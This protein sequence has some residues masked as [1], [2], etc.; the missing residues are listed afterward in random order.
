[1]EPPVKGRRGGAR[2]PRELTDAECREIAKRYVGGESIKRLMR[3][4]H[5][6]QVKI[7]KAIRNVGVAITETYGRKRDPTP[8]EIELA[9]ELIREQ[10]MKRLEASNPRP[11]NDMGD[12]PRFSLEPPDPRFNPPSI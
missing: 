8:A 10:N 9:K 5:C 6:G 12:V 7:R 4:F 3:Q 11:E 2:K 1:M